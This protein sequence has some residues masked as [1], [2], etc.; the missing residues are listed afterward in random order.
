MNQGGS[1]QF[2]LV[3]S[4]LFHLAILGGALFSIQSSRQELR[5]SETE[6]VAVGMITPGDVTKVR[7]GVRT[8]KLLAAAEAKESPQGDLAKKEATKPKMAATAPPPPPP[9]PAPEAKPEP[10][11]PKV[12]DPSPAPPPAAAEEAKKKVEAEQQKLAEEKRLAEAKQRSEE[13]AK[14]EA[15]KRAEEQ[16]KAEAEALKRAEEQKLAE[17][18]KIA[19][20]QRL[21]EERKRAEAEQKRLEEQRKQAELKKKRDEEKKRQ[22]E[23]KKKREAAEKKRLEDEKKRL[24]DEASKKQS[25]SDKMSAVLNKIPDAAPPPPSTA[26]DQPTKDK[27]PTLGAPD[28]KDRQLSASERG[29][30]QQTIKSCVQP[31]WNVLSGGASARETVVKIRIRL[32]PDGTLSA[33]PEVKPP[34]GTPTPYFR[35]I[36]E[37]ALRAVQECE[38]YDLP[39]DLYDHWK[40]VLM[41]FS[42][43]D[44]Y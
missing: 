37:S 4:V 36:S 40:D 10:S 30:I 14:A 15:L 28:G 24:A 25:F 33:P 18:K 12:V 32:N 27:G 20:E 35:A 19:E 22:A 2:G 31:R 7:Q 13:Q 23:L 34:P 3:I 38:P 44:M 1:V 43:T 17:E 16:A 29:L 42:P 39:P 8:A 6:P 21:A 41:A 11:P 9:P 5:L 26:G